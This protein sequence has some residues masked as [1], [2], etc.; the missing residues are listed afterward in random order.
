MAQVNYIKRKLLWL[1]IDVRKL[2][3]PRYT[4][5]RDECAVYLMGSHEPYSR[6]NCSTINNIKFN[7][8]DTLFKKK[9]WSFHRQNSFFSS[10]HWHATLFLTFFLMYQDRW[11]AADD[12]FYAR[13]IQQSHLFFVYLACFASGIKRSTICL[14]KG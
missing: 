2:I 6:T 9:N 12:Q 5:S 8:L 3:S 11:L 7:S 1:T 10:L 4:W 14:S 13:I